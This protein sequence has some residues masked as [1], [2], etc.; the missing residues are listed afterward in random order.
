LILIVVLFLNGTSIAQN[1]NILVLDALNGKPQEGV[2][3][4]YSCE[5]RHGA[6]T[7][8]LTTNKNGIA[9]IPFLCGSTG[10]VE[11]SVF[12]KD[13]HHNAYAKS[14]CGDLEPLTLKEIQAAGIVSNPSADGNIWCPTKISKKLKPVPGQVT[15]F[16]EKPTWWQVHVAG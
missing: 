14:Q 2:N 1:F 13:W 5:G 15:L 4:D 8:E 11:L 6:S 9:E 16:I 10:R 3:V 7:D 12:A